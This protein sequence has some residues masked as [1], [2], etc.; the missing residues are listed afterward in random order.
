[1]QYTDL[2]LDGVLASSMGI[3][4]T[5]MP[6]Y[7]RP[8]ERANAATIPGRSGSLTTRE[9]LDGVRVYDVVDYVIGLALHPDVESD[10]ALAWLAQGG[11]LVLG[12]MPGW[13]FDATLTGQVAT[14]AIFED[15]GDYRT[16]T[17]T[18]SCQP[19]RAPTAESCVNGYYAAAGYASYV[20]TAIAYAR[21]CDLARMRMRCLLG[22][23]TAVAINVTITREGVTPAGLE[24]VSRMLTISLTGNAI[25]DP[26]QK[27]VYDPVTLAD[28]SA[29]VT[30]AW[31][32]FPPR[33]AAQAAAVDRFYV[34][35]A[36]QQ[37]GA[38]NIDLTDNEAQVGSHA[39][40]Q[41]LPDWRR[42]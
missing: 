24:T 23:Y 12:S 17:C 39:M 1:M 18:Y 2:M 31:P 26:A 9:T 25:I 41:M 10:L 20:K 11:V 28:R 42:L 22:N 33:A 30:G 7:I 38:T 37:A 21:G 34:T 16:L 6:G 19:W 40:I 36:N 4:V 27:R 32:I 14:E 29:Q 15:G 8:A 13:A 35:V 5:Q 3:I